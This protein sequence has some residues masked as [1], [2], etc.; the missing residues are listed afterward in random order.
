MRQMKKSKKISEWYVI[1]IINHDLNYLLQAFYATYINAF[2]EK[3]HT[4][5]IEKIV[6]VYAA[7]WC[8]SILLTADKVFNL[9]VPHN[10]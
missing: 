8:L 7:G 10:N 4:W 6:K 5:K 9:H 3:K 2:Y 1:K